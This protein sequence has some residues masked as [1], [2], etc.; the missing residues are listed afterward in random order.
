LNIWLLLGVVVAAAG[1]MA[2]A[3]AVLA[4]CVQLL[5]LLFLLALPLR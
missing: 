1:T 3:A 2:A 4:G 5:G